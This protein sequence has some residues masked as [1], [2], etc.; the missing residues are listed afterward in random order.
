M[1]K[2]I[3][4]DLDGTLLNSTKDLPLELPHILGECSKNDIKFFLASG[5]SYLS[6]DL[7]FPTVKNKV[8]YIADNGAYV[9]DNGKCMFSSKIDSALFLEVADICKNIEDTHI[10]LCGT[11]GFYNIDTANKSI[12]DEVAT[13][14]GSSRIMV[15]SF[16]DI[17]DDIFKIAVYDARNPFDNSAKILN[18]NFGSK[19]SLA[20]SGDHW[21]DIMNT[22]INKGTALNL[23]QQKYNITLAETMAFGDFHNDI[24][25]LKAAKYSFAMQNAGNDIKACANYI[26]E[27]NDNNGVIKAINKYVFNK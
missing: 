5:R 26:A 10:T 2:L 24:E 20:V 16:N 17:E 15:K 21:F 14:Y 22:G 13:Y 1:I 27:S 8:G 19:L 11:K 4:A 18:A 23:I 3:A 12:E 6:L 9:V 7:Q 25:M